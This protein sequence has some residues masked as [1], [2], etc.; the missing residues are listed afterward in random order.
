MKPKSTSL[1]QSILLSAAMGVCLTPGAWAQNMFDVFFLT[2]TTGSMG[3][4]INGVQ[5]SSESILNSFLSGGRNV[6]FGVGEY[7]DGNAD[8]FGF[9]YNLTD[10]SDLPIL[11]EDRAAVLA[12][13]DVWSA[14][15]GGDYPEDNLLGLRE[16]AVSTPWRDG[17]RKII[18]WFGDA[19]GL[20]PASDGTTLADTLAA[21]GENCVQVIAIDLGGLDATGQ[22]T[23]ITNAVLNCG[24]DGGIIAEL[25]LGGLSG[26]EAAEA[27]EKLLIELFEE[28][29]GVRSDQPVVS[30]LHAASI[31]LTRTLTRDVGARLY[32]LRTGIRSEPVQ[33]TPPAPS[34]SA[35]DGAKDAKTP[36][37]M[38]SDYCKWEVYGQIY[39]YSEDQDKQFRTLS[40]APGQSIRIQTHGKT[41]ID[42]FG[43][44]VGFEYDFNSNWSAGFAIGA[45]GTR[46]DV[47][48]G[49]DADVDSLAFIPYVSYY[50]PNA[51]GGGDFY[52]DLLYAYT[53]HD[54]DMDQGPVSDSADGRAH[55]LEFTTG[56][57][58]RGGQLVHGPYASLRWIDGE[59]DDS[60][61]T[62]GNDIDYKSLATQLGYQ[63]S[64]PVA[65]GRGTLVPQGRVAWEHE[66]EE[67]QGSFAGLPL[68]ELDE[69][70][71]VLGAGIGYYTH[72][73]WNVVLDY[74][75]RLGSKSD[76]HYV[77]LKVGKEF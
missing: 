53:D 63:V 16:T 44:T 65:L 31:S 59:I 70:L 35:K 64:Y 42:T 30:A 1:R 25:N 72:G 33:G 58:F 12:A 76:S 41:S 62:G 46:I 8:A 28:A 24:L 61:F 48:P 3:G 11:S 2:D 9:R 15:G 51:V 5:S 36:I 26:E 21:L 68:G 57:N 7:K 38:P 74:E 69:D 39:Y 71:A 40:T 20:D 56:L 49:F 73:G 75:A 29:I 43:G 22:A 60:V 10:D 37:V 50:R 14:S 77:S 52:A 23:E 34:Y 18:F 4:L 17:S 47:D 27:I 55:Q 54:Y 66:F 19:P 13:I 32:R 67:S 45:A 6:A